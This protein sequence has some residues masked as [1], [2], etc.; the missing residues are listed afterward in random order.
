MLLVGKHCCIQKLYFVA[1]ACRAVHVCV[2]P[3][4]KEGSSA[5]NVRTVLSFDSRAVG[6]SGCEQLLDVYGLIGAGS[7]A[8]ARLQR[9]IGCLLLLLLLLL[10]RAPAGC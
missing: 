3:V 1:I 2:A 10:L 9:F 8:A 5:V 6:E 7:D 4:H